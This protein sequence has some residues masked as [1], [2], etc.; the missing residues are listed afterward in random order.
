MPSH[1]CEGLPAL[2][3]PSYKAVAISHSEST[4]K[5]SFMGG[6]HIFSPS[7]KRNQIGQTHCSMGVYTYGENFV[8][9]FPFATDDK[10]GV[11]LLNLGGPETLHDVQ[12]FLFNLFA[13]PVRHLIMY[14]FCFLTLFSNSLCLFVGSDS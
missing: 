8:E 11:L 10:V 12:P 9:S 1:S 6:S 14:S 7:E 4:S 3:K 5:S 2:C 13:D